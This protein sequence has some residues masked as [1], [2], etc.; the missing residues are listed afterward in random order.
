MSEFKV[1]VFSNHSELTK[2]H[3]GSD[4]EDYATMWD[5]DEPGS[6]RLTGVL[7]VTFP[8]GEIVNK[9]DTLVTEE[10]SFLDELDW[11]PELIQRAYNAG[12]D[13]GHDDGH[14]D[15]SYEEKRRA[16]ES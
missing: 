1:E 11:V 12:Y 8:D 10:A 16:N 9:G 2:N 5:Y 14:S 15:G 13:E 4:I 7:V 6:W 3:G